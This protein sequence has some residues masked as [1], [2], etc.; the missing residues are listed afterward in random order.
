[1]L[2]RA[3]M[4]RILVIVMILRRGFQP[5]RLGAA[6]VA[7]ISLASGVWTMLFDDLSSVIFGQSTHGRS[8][9]SQIIIFYCISQIKK[10]IKKLRLRSQRVI[11]IQSSSHA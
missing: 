3:F 1:M 7:M 10:Q 2:R 9:K 8:P 4:L 6:L 11:Q 5:S